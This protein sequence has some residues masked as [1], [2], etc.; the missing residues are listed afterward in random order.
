MVALSIVSIS[1]NAEVYGS[2][3]NALKALNKIN[4]EYSSCFSTFNLDREQDKYNSAEE[5]CTKPHKDALTK[6]ITNV[7]NE[8][9][10]LNAPKW[11][12]FN[13]SH[14]NFD[15]TCRGTP[16]TYYAPSYF[17]NGELLCEDSAYTSLAQ[18]AV[19]LSY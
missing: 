11:K 3:S 16:S 7:R 13:D 1:A 14:I 19:F 8:S 5:K 12:V 18:V 17:Y 15:R 2:K 10:L 9:K 6:F 4:T